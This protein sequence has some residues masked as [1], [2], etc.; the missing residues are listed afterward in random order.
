MEVMEKI[1]ITSPYNDNRGTYKHTAVDCISGV[2]NYNVRAV[3]RGKVIVVEN[4]MEDN[5]VV[6][7]ESPVE[8]WAGNY[9]IL[10][11]GN[12]Y[13]S[14]YNHLEFNSIKINVG[15]IVE[16]G[17]DFAREGKSGNA[18]AIHLDFEIR[19]NFDFID[20]TY[21]AIGQAF[22]PAYKD[23]YE[24]K[25]AGHVQDIG[26]TKWVSDGET[27]GTVGQANL[28]AYKESVNDTKYLNLNSDIDTW[29]VY[30]M[31]VAPIVGNECST[32]YP[33][34]F[35]GLSYTIKGYTN[36]SV[37]IIE[38]RDYG[39]VQIYIGNGTEGKCSISDNPVFGL[40]R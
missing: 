27:C 20:P 13:I 16:E 37:A 31:N 11:H 14:R 7:N 18:D 38:T 15:D 39:Q 19:C 28:P 17:Q 3:A 12:G 25:Y 1:E 29:R 9:V 10:E 24:I 22:L 6:N 5:K 2:S 34:R 35:G 21:Y 8:L 26:W 36:D 40:V 33:S 4:R 32:L 23:D 30:A